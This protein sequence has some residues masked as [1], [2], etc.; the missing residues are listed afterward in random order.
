MVG[1]FG[2][3]DGPLLYFTTPQ[4]TKT[5]GGRVV[6]YREA[7]CGAAAGKSLARMLIIVGLSGP[8]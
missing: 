1:P 5:I 3:Q 4:V 7:V 8:A 2:A 6:G